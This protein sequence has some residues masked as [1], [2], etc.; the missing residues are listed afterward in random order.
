MDSMKKQLLLVI[1][2]TGIFFSIPVLSAD[3]DMEVIRKRVIDAMMRP[4]VDEAS[5]GNIMNSLSPDGKWSG[6]NYIDVSRTGFQ[7]S[8]HLNNLVSMCRAYRKTGSQLKGNQVLKKAIS[9]ALGFWIENDFQC[10]NWWWNQ[11]GTPEQMVRILLI[12]DNELSAAQIKGILPI[13]GR[14]NLSAPG[15]RPSGDRIKIAG[16]LA[17]TMLFMRNEPSFSNVMSVIAG[18]IKFAA[19]RGMQYD[20]SFHHREDRVTSTLSY[21]MGYADAF[22]EWAE[23][24]AGTKYKFPDSAINLLVDYYLDGICQTMVFGKYPDPGAENRS[25]SRKGNLDPIGAATPE[26]LLK[27]TAYRKDE[28]EAIVRIRKD[29][30]RSNLSGTRFYWDSE[31]FSHQRPSWFASVRM[32]SSRNHNMEE[33]YNS[34]GLKNHHYADGSNFISRTG[35]EY[36]D[37]YPVLDWQKIPG[38]T[39]LQKDSLPPENLIQKKGLTDF[40]GAATDGNSGVA[41]FDFKSPHDPLGA[42]KSWFFFDNEYV[43]LGTGIASEA[44]LPVVTTLNQCLLK[45]AVT[46]LS[47]NLKVALR[48]GDFMLRGVK[49]ILHDSI[50]YIFT[51]T[52]TVNLMT[53]TA[54][55]SWYSI[56][57]Q[58][59]SPREEVSK[60]VFKLWIDHGLKPINSGYQYIVVPSVSEKDLLDNPGNRGIEVLANNNRVQAV[61]HALQN[62]IQA[63]FYS[64]GLIN[65][66][67]GLIL[68]AES[69]GIILISSESGKIS[70]ITVSDPSRQ[71]SSFSF[72][73]NRI[74]DSSGDFYSIKPEPDKSI[75]RVVITLPVNEH[76]GKSV[77]IKL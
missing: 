75:S 46:A 32:Y 25:I 49:W 59:D 73:V 19:G 41:A 31:Y 42:R 65:T 51:D 10:D 71:Q 70:S 40:V 77:T 45:G 21:G 5:V 37:I 39:V 26:R 12:M 43:C 28:L 3:P 2:I 54:T 30:I 74:I 50:A 58:A 38:T 18:E 8:E 63:V 23:L 76:A 6:I 4:S 53:D 11:I 24:A 34:E 44:S 66:S 68:G 27:A 36:F 29:E 1:A 62:M 16:I 60:E 22:A 15:A 48:K 14:A 57:H 55:G 17:K 35:E 64:P 20:Y 47:G 56:N 7:H 61:R 52:A 69:P 67:D 13:A 72:S 33:P 9:S